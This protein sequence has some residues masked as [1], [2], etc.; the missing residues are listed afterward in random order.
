MKYSLLKI[1][2]GKQL[3]TSR[4]SKRTKDNMLSYKANTITAKQRL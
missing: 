2:K 4:R 1:V 3:A